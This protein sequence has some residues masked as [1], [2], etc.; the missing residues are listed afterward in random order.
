M[1]SEQFGSYRIEA[2]IGRGGMGEVYRA[3]DTEHER[4]V[5]LK[6]LS[7]H[8]AADRGYRERFRRE[9]HLAARLNEPHVVPIHRYGEIEGRLFLDMRLVRG[10]DVAQVLARDGRF[11]PERAVSVVSQVAQALDAAHADG[12]V[13]RDVKP[14]NVLLTGSGDGEFAYLV[15]FGIA[16]S[17]AD[18]QGPSLTQTGAALGS[19]DYMAPERFLERDIDQRVDVYALACVLFEC[20]TGRRPFPRD[21]L[22]AQ[23]YAH[24]NTQ[25]ERPSS[26]APGIPTALDDVVARGLAKDPDARYSGAGELAAAAR[27][28]LAGSGGPPRPEVVVPQAPPTTIQDLRSVPQ[29]VGFTD[30]SG[31]GA[32]TGGGFG[33]AGPGTGGGFAPV[34][35]GT[36]GGFAPVRQGTGGGFAPP[37]G[38]GTGGGFGPGPGSWTAAPVPAYPAQQGTVGGFG[39]PTNGGTWGGPPAVPPP[40]ASSA[41]LWIAL[42]TT[43][44]IAVLVV[45]AVVVTRGR[46][47]DDVVTT[48]PTPS[49]TT[50]SQPPTTT[51]TT[52]QPTEE[53]TAY[54]ALRERIPADFDADSCTE[55]ELPGDGA[56][57]F[58]E[59]GSGLS[60]GGPEASGFYAYPDESTLADVFSTDVA[61]Q[62]V[63][64]VDG[65]DALP[66]TEGWSYYGDGNGNRAGAV[67]AFLL[68]DGTGVVLWTQYDA[69]AEGAVYV[70]DGANDLDDLWTWWNDADK[71]DF[72]VG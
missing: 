44:V 63:T 37:V 2:L 56:E 34:G 17:T 19:F 66:A 70:T 40:R 3:Y 48:D 11:S 46:G 47:G 60:T 9:A 69:L 4:T 55:E 38:G 72:Q 62:G 54:D 58:L 14:S 25:V 13:H 64:Q 32:G 71:S 10:D 50:V 7:E 6:V 65:L 24:V 41:V 27:A 30:P 12:L 33:P 29:T 42:V 61:G 49:T 16:R 31:G 23:M 53:A 8:L 52:T 18:S 57:A 1:E 26:L 45:V 21:G 59:C 43:V 20:L 36:V 51:P 15:D 68:E 28:A 22:G 35:P 5:A 67:A 39:P